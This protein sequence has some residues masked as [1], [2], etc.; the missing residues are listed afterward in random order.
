MP[1]QPSTNDRPAEVLLTLEEV[2]RRLSVSCRTVYRIID[3]G[4]LPVVRV[5]RAVRVRE[6]ALDRY[7][8]THEEGGGRGRPTR[9]CA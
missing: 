7:I 3:E 1:N 8:H 6:S 2:G 4:D 9:G 5:R